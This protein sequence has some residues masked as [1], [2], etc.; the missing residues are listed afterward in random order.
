MSGLFLINRDA[1]VDL[2]HVLH[3]V[4]VGA[5]ISF[6]L[7]ELSDAAEDLR[8]VNLLVLLIGTLARVSVPDFEISFGFILELSLHW[9]FVEE[10]SFEVGIGLGA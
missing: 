9:W 6:L 8:S 5:S 3:P 4:F 7:N 2:L 1:S 10:F